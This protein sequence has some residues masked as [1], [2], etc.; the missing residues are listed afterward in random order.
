MHESLPRELGSPRG[1]TSRR[2]NDLTNRSDKT[3]CSGPEL[4]DFMAP[5]HDAPKIT[6]LAAQ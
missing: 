6:G 1:A 3:D 2:P 4:I 5:E